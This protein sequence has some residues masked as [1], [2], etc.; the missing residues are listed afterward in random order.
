VTNDML[1]EISQADYGMGAEAHLAALVALRDEMHV[2]AP[3]PWEPKEVLQL[4]RWSQPDDPNVQNASTGERGHTIRAFCC[5]ALL[6]AAAEPANE[7]YFDGENST[8][9]QLIESA[10]SLERGLPE[11]AGRFL[12]WRI[13]RMRTDDEESPL[14]AFG[15]LALAGLI[16]PQPLVASDVD[17]LVSFVENVEADLRDPTGAC[18]R[19]MF[20]GSSF[21]ACT[22]FDLR[23][24][25]WR[26]L[27]VRLR[28]AMPDSDRVVA[29]AR[30]VELK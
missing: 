1:E 24:A 10:L 11:L 8:L 15:L 26:G 28:S 22:N 3:M 5:A 9:I 12:T 17:E 18:T 23:H 27:A 29:L 2:P 14:F 20:E 21:L 25:A 16:R 7:G 6:R 30:R 19:E 13:P 4:V